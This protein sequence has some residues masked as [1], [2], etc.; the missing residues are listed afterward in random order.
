MA[1]KWLGAG[2]CPELSDSGDGEGEGV[3]RPVDAGDGG[4][5]DD[6][7]GDDME[8]SLRGSGTGLLPRVLTSLPA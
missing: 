7:D 6:C 4:V 5:E 8:D 3:G 1:K 2:L